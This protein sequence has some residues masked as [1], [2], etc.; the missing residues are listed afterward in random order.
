MLLLARVPKISIMRLGNSFW[1]NELLGDDAVMVMRL[2]ANFH[3]FHRVL[4]NTWNE[5]NPGQAGLRPN[6]ART[7][8]G[9]SRSKQ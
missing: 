2:V 4:V 7:N 3:D 9:R 8:S 1:R 6:S 5:A